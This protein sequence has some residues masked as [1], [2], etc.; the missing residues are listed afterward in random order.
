MP[1]SGYKGPLP[2]STLIPL[3]SFPPLLL[4]QRVFPEDTWQRVIPSSTPVLNWGALF[5]MN[6]YH[7]VAESIPALVVGILATRNLPGVRVLATRRQVR[8]GGREGGRLRVRGGK[9]GAQF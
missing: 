1:A 5:D 4:V 8:E 3:P 7:F 2:S 9:K 6:F